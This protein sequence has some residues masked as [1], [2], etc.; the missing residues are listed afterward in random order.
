VNECIEPGR[1]AGHRIS[2][3][4]Q[5]HLLFCIRQTELIHEI[6]RLHGCGCN[7]FQRPRDALR[8]ASQCVEFFLMKKVRPECNADWPFAVE[9]PVSPHCAAQ[10]LENRRR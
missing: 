9:Q 3:I 5:R 10:L 2:R 1:Y 6:R 8:G 7:L 4:D